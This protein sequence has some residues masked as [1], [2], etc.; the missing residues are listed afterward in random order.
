MSWRFAFCWIGV[1]KF[2]FAGCWVAPP[3]L[4]ECPPELSASDGSAKPATLRILVVD[5]CVSGLPPSGLCCSGL[6]ARCYCPASRLHV[7]GPSNPHSACWV[8]ACLRPPLLHNQVVMSEGGSACPAL[9]QFCVCVI[10]G[11]LLARTLPARSACSQDVSACAL[12]S[13]RCCAAG[14]PAHSPPSIELK[15]F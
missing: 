9:P 1:P 12:F 8:Q 2:I 7:S 10:Q 14:N 15:L 4:A 13:Q 5:S 3:T 6:G 11:F